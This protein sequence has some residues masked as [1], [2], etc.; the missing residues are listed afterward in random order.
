[1]RSSTQVDE[2]QRDA[3]GEETEGASLFLLVPGGVVIPPATSRQRRKLYLLEMF[4]TESLFASVLHFLQL[5][6]SGTC[7]PA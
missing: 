3:I 2:G 6:L 1:M 7:G 5:H 4:W